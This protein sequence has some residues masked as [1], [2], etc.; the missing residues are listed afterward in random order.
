MYFLCLHLK[1]LIYYSFTVS[2]DLKEKAECLKAA[3]NGKPSKE[4][5][6]PE[7]PRKQRRDKKNSK[8]LFCY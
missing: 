6:K 4:A 7:K 2:L 8:F 1:I 3:L 5:I